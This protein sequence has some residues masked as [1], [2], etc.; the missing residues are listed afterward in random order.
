MLAATTSK[1][2]L[3]SAD[4]PQSLFGEQEPFRDNFNRYRT[5]LSELVHYLTFID[6][7][8][9]MTASL[10]EDL[11]LKQSPTLPLD[12]PALPSHLIGPIEA[13]RKVSSVSRIHHL[14]T[15][16]LTP[17]CALI[18]TRNDTYREL[19]TPYPFTDFIQG[20]IYST[21]GAD[22]DD[23]SILDPTRHLLSHELFH[24]HPSYS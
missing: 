21:S 15:D 5:P 13:P 2:E 16:L 17:P 24:M 20:C 19:F 10:G 12:G 1:R 4:T 7:D 6:D 18:G 8:H 3:G 9:E 14:Q 11:L 23:V 22:T